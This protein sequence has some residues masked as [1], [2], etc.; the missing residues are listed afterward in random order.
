[1][2]EQPLIT[3]MEAIEAGEPPRSRC[4]KA[5]CRDERQALIEDCRVLADDADTQATIAIAL[6]LELLELRSE[7]SEYKDRH[8]CPRC[9]DEDLVAPSDAPCASEEV[10]GQLT[11]LDEA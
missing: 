9:D 10:P 11:L 6:T 5:E 2:N 7:F 1:M 8:P 4:H 3:P